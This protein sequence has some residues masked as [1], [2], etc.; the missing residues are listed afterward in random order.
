MLT[1]NLLTITTNLQNQTEFK[2]LLNKFINEF[3]INM[4]EIIGE[5]GVFKPMKLEEY[6]PDPNTYYFYIYQNDTLVGFFGLNNDKE[7][8]TSWIVEFYLEKKY[9]TTRYCTNILTFIQNYMNL[10]NMKYL[11]IGVF[12]IKPII[13]LT[14]KLGFNPVIT[15]MIKKL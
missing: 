10:D 8:F 1:N 13:A 4:L 11:S 7:L 2:N 15:T 12:N 3:N 14:K 5:E 9:R 6:L